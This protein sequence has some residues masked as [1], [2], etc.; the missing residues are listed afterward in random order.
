MD[1]RKH[2]G[3]YRNRAMVGEFRH[4]ARRSTSVEQGRTGDQS[5]GHWSLSLELFHALMYFERWRYKKGPL[6]TESL[7]GHVLAQVPPC[8]HSA[9]VSTARDI[10]DRCSSFRRRHGQVMIVESSMEIIGQ[11]DSDRGF[12]VPQS[13]FACEIG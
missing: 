2:R 8:R 10:G 9:M 1:K 3:S 11:K 13:G 4:L 7:A 6:L 5:E 12:R